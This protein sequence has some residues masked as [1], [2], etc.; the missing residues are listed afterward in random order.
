MGQSSGCVEWTRI[1][2]ACDEQRVAGGLGSKG[3]CIPYFDRVL[4]SLPSSSLHAR[5][6]IVLDLGELEVQG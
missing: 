4:S 6:E 2:D 1:R 5:F 3:R